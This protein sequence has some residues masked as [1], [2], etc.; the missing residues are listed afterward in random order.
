MNYKGYEAV[1][2]IEI[3]A[4]LDTRSKIFCSC[5]T[6]Y[7]AEP[8]TQ[9]CPVCMGFPGTLPTLN[10]RAV[11]LALIAGRVTSCSL[12]EISKTDRK[13]YF[14]PDLPKAYQI[15]QYDLPICE[16]GWLDIEYEGQEKRIGITR[17]HIE[18]DAGKLFHEGERTYID[19]NR[20][21]VPLVEIVTEPDMR[22]AGEAV[23]FLSALRLD[24]LFA[25]VSKCKMNEGNLRF[26]V[27]LSVRKIG[28]SSLYTRTE[29]KNLNSFAN[30][31]RAIELEF[32][33][34]VDTLTQGGRIEQ[35]T[36]RY[37]EDRDCVVFMREKENAHG[38]RYFPEPDI[39]P[40]AISKE[41]IEEICACIPRMP[42]ER[43]RE[44]IEKYALSDDGTAIL[45][46]SPEISDY[47]ELAAKSS[48][49]PKY[50]A[51]LIIGELLRRAEGSLFKAM[52][53]EHMAELSDMAEAGEINSSTAKRLVGLLLGKGTSPAVY[54]R[55]NGMLQIK[56]EGVILGFVREAIAQDPRSVSDYVRG[57]QNA[58]KAIFGAV[59]KKSRGNADPLTVEC[60]LDRELEKMK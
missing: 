48:H 45:T 59:M 13:N 17:I 60:L 14:Y 15:S 22:S 11:E 58:K 20:C 34:Q 46:S 18:E 54:A 56:D 1:I 49:S 5:S 36:L 40:I 47:F 39:P 25:G 27:N 16:G 28:D 3:H 7:G 21:G 33:R 12:R 24:L 23:A 10:R 55:E 41:E 44:Y 4:E 52:P 43:A 42:R 32:K 2:G 30:V 50:T 31:E 19:Y 53:P 8:N 29:M 26:D 9:V 35:G 57:K 6:S 38:Y 51:N 37:D